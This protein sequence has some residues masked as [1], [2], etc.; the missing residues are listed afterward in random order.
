MRQTK[1]FVHK[2]L[3][4]LEKIDPSTL[5]NHLLNLAEQ[6]D[7]FRDIFNHLREGVLLLDEKGV[8]RFLN[9]RAS[10]WLNA[11]AHSEEAP[12]SLSQLPDTKL[13]KL[14]QDKL[15]NLEEV[16]IEDVQILNPREAYLRL[17]LYW[18][19]DKK[20]RLALAIFE[21]RTESTTEQ[22][23]F[24]RLARIESLLKLAAGVAHEIGNPLNTMFIHLQLLKKSVGDL[25]Q[26]EQSKLM[27]AL[28]TIHAE[29]QRLHRIVKNFVQATRKPPLRFTTENLNQIIEQAIEFMAPDFS[30]RQIR[31][32]FLKD[33]RLP[34]FLID[35]DRLYQVFINLIKNAVEAMPQGGRI[36]IRTQSR[37]KA[38]RITIED[39]GTGIPQEHLP[40]IFDAYYTTKEEGSGLGLMTVYNA[41]SE[42]G[43]EISAANASRGTVFTITLP[44]RQ[45]TLQLPR[46]DEGKSSQRKS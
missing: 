34:E 16:D 1:N 27:P 43:G 25:N 33:N 21:D 8:I 39:E 40:H 6:I 2:L 18:I 3:R 46:Y 37:A 36:R 7:V 23:A 38:C 42:H 32:E 22:L 13:R 10:Y 30:A 12:L 19:P 35:R 20:H 45:K 41:I 28:E 9:E 31:M 17:F 29:T 5:Q 14:L 11:G 24:A 15:L 44:I 26:K 4:R